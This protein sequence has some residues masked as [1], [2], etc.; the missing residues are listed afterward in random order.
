M[1]KVN[2]K[3]TRTTPLASW[4]CLYSYLWTYF[5]PCSSVSIVNFEQVNDS[6][7]RQGLIANPNKPMF[8]FLCQ[9][10]P[11]FCSICCKTLKNI[12]INKNS[13]IKWVNV[14]APIQKVSKAP[15]KK[16]LNITYHLFAKLHRWRKR[17]WV[18]T[19]YITEID[20][21]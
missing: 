13:W 17:F 21:K 7:E 11:T 2:N 18:A 14:N 19:K 9:C 1:F 12:K 10:F 15:S 5:T 3:D 4:W 8:S 6:W 16:I 20:M